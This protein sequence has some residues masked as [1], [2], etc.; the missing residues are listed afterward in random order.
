MITLFEPDPPPDPDPNPTPPPPPP[1]HRIAF[2]ISTVCGLGYMPFAPGTFGSLAG[3]GIYW[4]IVHI[5]LNGS[6]TDVF[7]YTDKG[8]TRMIGQPWELL[9]WH[10]LFIAGVGLVA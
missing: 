9:C 6:L 8:G 4:L 1:K 7:I 10:T 2:F 5:W 3:I